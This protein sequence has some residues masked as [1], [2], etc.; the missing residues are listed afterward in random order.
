MGSAR[1]WSER[2][3][4]RGRYRTASARLVKP[5]EVACGALLDF[6]PARRT[7]VQGTVSRLLSPSFL[8]LS[9]FDYE[10]PA[11]AI[12]QVPLD[13]R[14]SARLLVHDRSSGRT[15]HAAMSDLPQWLDSGDLVVANDTRV[16]P[17]RLVALRPGGGR[18]ELLFLEPLEGDALRW[19]VMAKPAARLRA[20]MVLRVVGSENGIVCE[21]RPC[22]EDGTPGPNWIVRGE[23]AP[24]DE[25]FLER[26]GQLPLPPY[27]ERP[28]GPSD[29]D[30]ERYQTV[31]ADS[32]GAVAAPTAG[33][34]L[35]EALLA[36]IEG[37][38]A[39]FTTVTLHVG[40][41]TFRPVDQADPRLHQMHTERYSVA[42]EAAEEVDALRERGG[43]LLAVGTTSLRTLETCAQP[44]RRIA[45][46]FGETDLFLLPGAEFQ[47][48]DALLTNFHLPRSTLLM[49]VSAFA[50]TERVRE[51]YREA[52]DKGY[53]FA[54]YGDGMLLL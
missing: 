40:A 6:A 33:L 11:S 19:R 23:P 51:L 37:R 41:G 30:R 31:F 45:A 32:V 26:F 21:E 3:R 52:L 7:P 24:L 42:R 50:G 2:L 49:L 13:R 27:V 1:S 15:T 46:G 43:R 18:T 36:G 34:H 38:G 35:S 14:E 16:R 44:E 39:R 47:V 8:Q 9:D 28:E 5:G 54:S 25:S 4:S 53:R 48:V 10:L 12:A 29:L 22:S 20:G 17:A